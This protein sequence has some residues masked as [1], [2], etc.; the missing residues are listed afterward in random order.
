MPSLPGGNIQVK[1]KAIR[2]GTDATEP[3]S[4]QDPGQSITINAVLESPIQ[5]PGQSIMIH[6][7]SDGC[8]IFPAE[9]K[10][11]AKEFF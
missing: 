6:A 4:N 8:P 10:S 5:D 1:Y 3:R 7:V 9:I 2:G 11:L